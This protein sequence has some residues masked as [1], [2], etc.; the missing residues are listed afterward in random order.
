MV[1]NEISNQF[2]FIGNN[3]DEEFVKPN[4]QIANDVQNEIDEIN[5]D[6]FADSEHRDSQ[7]LDKLRSLDG[8]KRFLKYLKLN[9]YYFF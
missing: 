4:D 7:L 2:F 9:F 8:K 6:L 1:K 5:D 3:S